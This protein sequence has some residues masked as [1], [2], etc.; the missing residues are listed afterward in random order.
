MNTLETMFYL[1]ATSKKVSNN[2][3]NIESC[4]LGVF[5]LQLNGLVIPSM[6]EFQMMIYSHLL[7]LY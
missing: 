6:E 4:D 5:H 2:S 3:F 7:R 1:V